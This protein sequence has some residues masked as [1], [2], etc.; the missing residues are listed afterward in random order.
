MDDY[1]WTIGGSPDIH[2]Y[3]LIAVGGYG[4]VHEVYSKSGLAN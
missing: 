3:K 4:E 1:T 2:H